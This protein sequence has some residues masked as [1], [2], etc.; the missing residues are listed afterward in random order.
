M[1]G[2]EKRCDMPLGAVLTSGAEETF[3]GPAPS[4][5]VSHPLQGIGKLDPSSSPFGEAG[6]VIFLLK[7]SGRL[8]LKLRLQ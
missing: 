2:I 6:E 4:D 3:F 8:L 5:I 7:D 1:L